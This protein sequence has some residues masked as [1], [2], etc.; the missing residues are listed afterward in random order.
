MQFYLALLDDKVRMADENPAIG[1]I[2]CKSKDKTT[3]EYALRES[4]KPIGV[5]S[6]RIVRRLPAEM[7]NLLPSPNQIK[8]ILLSI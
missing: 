5:A 7:K 4:K 8:E 2:L 1:I 3:V 6:Y